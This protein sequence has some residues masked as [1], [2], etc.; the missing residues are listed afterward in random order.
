MRLQ[1]TLF[2]VGLLVFLTPFLGFTSTVDKIILAVMGIL[3]VVV[4]ILNIPPKH[5]N[6]ESVFVEEKPP[7]AEIISSSDK[8]ISSI[9]EPLSQNSNSSDTSV[10]P[11]SNSEKNDELTSNENVEGKEI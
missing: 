3:I 5:H 2:V 11:E 8:S 7:S 9:D 4:S 6:P 10:E 1:K